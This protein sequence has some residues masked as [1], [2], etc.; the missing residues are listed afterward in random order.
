MD[1]TVR[2]A[3]ERDASALSELNREWNGDYAPDEQQ[4]ALLLHSNNEIVMLATLGGEAI[5]FLCGRIVGS[6]CH[7]SLHGE[8]AELFVSE[9]YRKQG[10]ARALIN[11]ME[12]YFKN[13]GITIVTLSTSA[14]NLSA[15]AC[16][17]N[18]GYA[19]NPRFEYRKVL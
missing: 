7:K 12:G 18:C 1:I 4:T 5:G 17:K 14:S 2:T 10:A 3:S 19:G 16:Y 9:R 8:I 6:I 15:Q 11:S 13:R